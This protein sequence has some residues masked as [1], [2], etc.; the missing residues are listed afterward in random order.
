MLDFKP[1]S[2]RQIFKSFSRAETYLKANYGVEEL[3][4]PNFYLSTNAR[5]NILEDFIDV[6]L[7]YLYDQNLKRQIIT[8][9]VSQI[10]NS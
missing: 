10:W 5:M 7:G 2:V 8:E 9:L 3:S 4:D 6:Y 1:L